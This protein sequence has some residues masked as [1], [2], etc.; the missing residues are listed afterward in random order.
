MQ[1]ASVGIEL[2]LSVVIGL[3]GGRWLDRKLGT[4]PYLSLVGLLIGV[5]AGFRGLIRAARKAQREAEAAS[6]ADSND[7]K[8]HDAPPRDR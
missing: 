4:D 1:L 8:T 2:S 6:Q 3:L 5:A 7:T